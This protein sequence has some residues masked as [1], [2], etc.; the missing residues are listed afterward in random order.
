MRAVWSQKAPS[1]TQPMVPMASR[2][3]EP[4][5][6]KTQVPKPEASVDG[7]D[8]GLSSRDLRPPMIRSYMVKLQAQ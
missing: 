6:R 4:S 1:A 5:D 3:R 8:L 7:T 2:G